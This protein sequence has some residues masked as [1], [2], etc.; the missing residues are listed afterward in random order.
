MAAL[1]IMKISLSND[2]PQS[3]VADWLVVPASG[4]KPL[5]DP[6]LQKL[7]RALGG[8]IAAEVK[9]E[10][11]EA[12]RAKSLVV[13]GRGRVKAKHILIVG[14][15]EG[16]PSE[17]MV[18]LYGVKAGRAAMSNTALAVVAPSTDPTL[19]RALAD[20]VATGA[21]RYTRYLTGNRAPKKQLTKAS[22]LLE[23]KP[24]A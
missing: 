17:A 7:D 11:F 16:V 3:V 22:G 18:R 23:R 2:A 19:L 5:Q 12:K 21:Y 9:E 8:A 10:A 15:G 14:L 4:K 6:V 13:A 24:G 20:G 1:A